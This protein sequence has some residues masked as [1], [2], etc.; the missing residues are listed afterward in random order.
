MVGKAIG[1]DM[2]VVTKLCVQMA[3]PVPFIDPG[4]RYNF[5]R[6][7]SFTSTI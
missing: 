7:A 1:V 4:S 5:S 3:D 2:Q 6:S